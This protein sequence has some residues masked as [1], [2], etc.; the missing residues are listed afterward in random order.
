MVRPGVWPYYVISKVGPAHRIFQGES[1]QKYVAIKE[2][3]TF[4]KRYDELLT[5][6][7][8]PRLHQTTWL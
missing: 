2:N 4:D 1:N 5:Y 8:S 7:F 6:M 3:K